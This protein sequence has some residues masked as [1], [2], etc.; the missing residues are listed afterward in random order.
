MSYRA[1]P[2][3]T[4]NAP[5]PRGVASRESVAFYVNLGARLRTVEE[6]AR[7]MAYR[8]Q[9]RAA[10]RR[11]SYSPLHHPDHHVAV[12][13]DF[14]RLDALKTQVH[15]LLPIVHDSQFP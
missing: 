3:T 8:A 12:N 4:F 2:S 15:A 5:N 9:S 7:A 1:L 11:V 14:A 6:F 10:K 13:R